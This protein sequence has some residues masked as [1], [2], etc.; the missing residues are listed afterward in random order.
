[1]IQRRTP[2]F[3]LV[4]LGVFAAT[5]FAAP[6]RPPAG[7]AEEE[8]WCNHV[9]HTPQQPKSNQPVK[10]TASIAANYTAVALQYQLV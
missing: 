4:L 3:V 6:P 8:P 10:I 2:L 7:V 1:M 5:V 9:T